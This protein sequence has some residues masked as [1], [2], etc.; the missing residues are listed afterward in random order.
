MIYSQVLVEQ[1]NI[2]EDIFNG[3]EIVRRMVNRSYTGVRGDQIYVGSARERFHQYV[4]KYF[5]NQTLNFEVTI[6]FQSLQHYS[7]RAALTYKDKLVTHFLWNTG[8]SGMDCC[9]G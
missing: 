6:G 4:I 1:M 5:N 9:K 8:V 2:G 3:S 7:T